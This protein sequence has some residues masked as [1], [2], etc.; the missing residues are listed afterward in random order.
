[1]IRYFYLIQIILLLF[2]LGCATSEELQ[3]NPPKDYPVTLIVSNQNG[4]NVEPV[5]II[6]KMKEYSRQRQKTNSSE[7]I[8]VDQDF[9]NKVGHSN[10]S[11]KLNLKEGGHRI[12][13]ETKNNNYKLDVI[14]EVDRPM[15]LYLS[16]LS[17]NQF[18]LHIS[19]TPFVFG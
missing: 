16:Y 11:F 10:S 8:I 12:I 18:R 3:N 15:W 2:I 19:Y 17:N 6:V 4:F 13:A 1:M 9:Y 14:F 5:H 7:I